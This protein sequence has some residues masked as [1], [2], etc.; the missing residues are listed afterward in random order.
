MFRQPDLAATLRKM[1]E[2]ERQALTAGKSRKDAILA[3]YNRFYLRPSYLAQ[4]L[5][6][7][8]PGLRAAERFDSGVRARH[9]RHERSVMAK[10]V[11]C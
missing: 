7:Q 11:I 4:L 9:E 5:R 8:G 2:A 6:L 3:A 10:A 1:V